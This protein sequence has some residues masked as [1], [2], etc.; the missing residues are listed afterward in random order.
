M[1]LEL[2]NL[3][4]EAHMITLKYEESFMSVFRSWIKDSMELNTLY[5]S[6]FNVHLRVLEQQYFESNCRPKYDLSKLFVAQ[7]IDKV[8][9]YVA[10]IEG[11]THQITI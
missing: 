7:R 6:D 3:L 5:E 9:Y 8:F 10:G 1:H 4:W 11:N 2:I